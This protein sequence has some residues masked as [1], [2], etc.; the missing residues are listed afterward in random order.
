MDVLTQK[1]THSYFDFWNSKNPIDFFIFTFIFFFF[2]F[3]SVIDY[4]FLANTLL[5][6]MMRVNI[7]RIFQ[8]LIIFICVNFLKLFL[9]RV[10]IFN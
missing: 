10:F 5:H 6:V 8:W 4:L 1:C 7:F 9:F 3:C 2:F